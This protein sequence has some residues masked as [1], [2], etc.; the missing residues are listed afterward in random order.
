MELA[1]TK[2]DEGLT[3]L[4]ALAGIDTPQEKRD[5]LFVNSLL[6][7]IHSYIMNSSNIP[8]D[9]ANFNL[10]SITET[11]IFFDLIFAAHISQGILSP[12]LHSVKQ[13]TSHIMR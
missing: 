6:E 11:F 3:T 2:G 7:I 13:W 1:I 10:Y 8:V 4:F 5:P 12:N 9:I